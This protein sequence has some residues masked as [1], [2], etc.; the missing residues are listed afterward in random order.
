MLLAYHKVNKHSQALYSSFVVL[1]LYLSIS[2]INLSINKVARESHHRI[3]LTNL[4]Y[5]KKIKCFIVAFYP[6]S[7]QAPFQVNNTLSAKLL[8]KK[9]N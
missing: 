5:R 2:V 9:Y 8:K 3:F 7:S 4:G 6:R 1:Y